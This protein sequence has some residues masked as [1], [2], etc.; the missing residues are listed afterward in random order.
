VTSAD[1]T[2]ILV[3]HRLSTLKDADRIVVFE[4][5]RIVEVGTYNELLQRGGKLAQLVLSGEQGSDGPASP[6]P[7]QP[8]TAEAGS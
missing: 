5:G 6:S 8:A 3:A 2:T 4:E 7:P 1:R